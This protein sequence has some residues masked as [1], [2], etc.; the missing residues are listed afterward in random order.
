MALISNW[1]KNKLIRKDNGI[2]FDTYNSDCFNVVQDFL[3][4][5]DCKFKTHAIY[6]QAFPEESALEFLNTLG[7]ELTSKLSRAESNTKRSL[8][9]IIQDSELKLIL[10]DNCHLHPQDT[11]QNLINFFAVCEVGVILIGHDDKMA[12]A[13]IL[14]NPMLH[15]W[16]S[17]NATPERCE[18]SP[19]IG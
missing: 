3:E 16:D 9:E 17:I 18:P 2:I 10:I 12:I 5:C 13:Q 14:S 8:L 4:S 1:L 15:Q 11:L 6:Y 19:K 7:E